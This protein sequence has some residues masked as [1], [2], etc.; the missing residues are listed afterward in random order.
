MKTDQEIIESL[1]EKF[2]QE[3]E[4]KQKKSYLSPVPTKRSNSIYPI[5][6]GDHS[7]ITKISN[8]DLTSKFNINGDKEIL[9]GNNPIPYTMISQAPEMNIENNYN[10][11]EIRKNINNDDIVYIN[12]FIIASTELSNICKGLC[13]N[14]YGFGKVISN[15]YGTNMLV[16]FGI[17]NEDNCIYLVPTH[18]LTFHARP[19]LIT[20]EWF[21]S[22]DE[23]GFEIQQKN[24]EPMFIDR[25]LFD[26]P[27]AKTPPRDPFSIFG[28]EMSSKPFPEIPKGRITPK[29]GKG[30]FSK[31][32]K[33]I[34]NIKNIKNKTLKSG[35]N[36]K[37]GKKGKKHN[38]S[39]QP[40]KKQNKK[41]EKKQEKKT[42]ADSIKALALFEKASKQQ[43]SDDDKQKL[44]DKYNEEYKLYNYFNI[45]NKPLVIA[46]KD[47]HIF[48]LFL[49]D[50]KD[51][52]ELTE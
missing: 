38:K 18:F 19:S 9:F 34:K 22:N 31:T 48:M 11:Y 1:R 51:K 30:G 49:S 47:N 6:N 2:Q 45:K 39:Y 26:S 29:S 35:G 10:H 20:T 15:D 14:P 12:D 42:I 4:E 28:E 24:N 16:H 27:K 52:I 41:Q 3:E 40:K 23:K 25:S 5:F 50:K 32:T 21:M 33:N 44:F 37:K 36:S 46:E 13:T 8:S 43:I 7:Q 17:Y